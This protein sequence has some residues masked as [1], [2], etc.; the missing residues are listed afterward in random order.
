MSEHPEGYWDEIVHVDEDGLGYARRDYPAKD[1]PVG[2]K[3]MLG[4]IPSVTG[5]VVKPHEATGHPGEGGP[6][7]EVPV[8]WFGYPTVVDWYH[9]DGLE[10]L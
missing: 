8:R 4:G 6:T 10:R 1:Y 7:H 9:V 2:T 3:V 5:V